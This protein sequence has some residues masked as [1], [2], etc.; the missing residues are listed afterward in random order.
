MNR[1]KNS[2][3]AFGGLS[4][5]IAAVTFVSPKS[6][7]SSPAPDA[8]D[9]VVINTPANPVPIIAQGTTTVTGNVSV[10]GTVG[11]NPSAN[12]VKVENTTNP[13]SVRDADTAARQ[14]H[15][16]HL[17]QAL[18]AG[19]FDITV[20]T[21]TVPAGNRFVIEYV[22]I[23]ANGP[24][25]F[26][27]E[28]VLRVFIG[29]SQSLYDFLPTQ[30]SSVFGELISQQVKIYADPGQIEFRF[31]RSPGGGQEIIFC[32]RLVGYLEPA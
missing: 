19:Q 9:V 17:C 13:L 10:T 21:Y 18:P 27:T 8:R 16:V 28:A 25:D 30:T 7:L 2:L 14:V 6:S 4:V 11:I 29:G 23:K 12:I 32:A 22:H 1:I 15:R 26:D 3:I 31:S 20:P 5:L 24:G